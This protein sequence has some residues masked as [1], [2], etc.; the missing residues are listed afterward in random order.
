MI[1]DNLLTKAKAQVRETDDLLKRIED[2]Q[3]AMREADQ[4]LNDLIR[5]GMAPTASRV[6]EGNPFA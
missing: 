1:F 3:A 5:M 6:K 4:R 2:N